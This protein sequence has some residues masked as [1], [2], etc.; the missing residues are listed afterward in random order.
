MKY[1]PHVISLLQQRA[2]V[3]LNHTSISTGTACA[4][5]TPKATPVSCVHLAEGKF[6]LRGIQ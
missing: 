1:A 5:L 3:C 2:R 6:D 4:C